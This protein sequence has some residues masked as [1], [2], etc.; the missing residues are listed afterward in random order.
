MLPEVDACLLVCIRPSGRAREF[1]VSPVPMEWRMTF[2]EPAVGVFTPAGT[3]PRR[4]RRHCVIG[5]ADPGPNPSAVSSGSSP[6]R[7][8]S[9]G[10]ATARSV[11]S[12]RPGI[13]TDAQDAVVDVGHAPRRRVACVKAMPCQSLGEPGHGAV[14]PE[15]AAVKRGKG[16]GNCRSLACLVNRFVNR[17]LRDSTRRGETGETERDGICPVR[18]GHRT[19]E[20]RLE[21]V[22]TYV[23]WLITQRSR[24]QIPPPLPRPEALSRTEEGPS[25]CGLCTDLCTGACSSRCAQAAP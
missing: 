3:W 9:L 8:R 24:V 11:P 7:G 2:P 14:H 20:R 1:T 16:A 17:T 13:S 12:C 18:R 23:V 10:R 25:A 6:V 22:E 5:C 19:R 15:M 4:L 21:T